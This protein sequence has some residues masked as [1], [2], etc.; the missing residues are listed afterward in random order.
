MSEDK[1]KKSARLSARRQGTL[2]LLAVAGV[3]LV[4]VVVFQL[5]EGTQRTVTDEGFRFPQRTTATRQ[6][7]L[8]GSPKTKLKA[9]PTTSGAA[10]GPAQGP[11]EGDAPSAEAE[12]DVAESPEDQLLREARNALDPRTGIT[13]IE[14]FLAKLDN[15]EKAAEAYSALGALYLELGDDYAEEAEGALLTARDLGQSAE[16][17]HE[18]SHALVTAL[19][20]RGDTD[21]AREEALFALEYDQAP[22]LSGLRIQVAL[23][24]LHESAGAVDEAEAAYRKASEDAQAGTARWG[25]KAT[26]VHRQA[27][28]CLAR[29][30]RKLGRIDDADAVARALGSRL[31]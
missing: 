13:K 21:Q 23:G 8:I 5:Q 15:L 7:P 28:L 29:L 26:A 17:R 9:R 25:E 3:V 16:A 22:T 31:E 30:Y 1:G 24:R 27:C 6:K 11:P 2:V 18:A 14:R 20:Q 12:P 19:M 4:L 10:E